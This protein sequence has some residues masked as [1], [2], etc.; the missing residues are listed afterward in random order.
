MCIGRMSMKLNKYDSMDIFL[1]SL[2]KNNGYDLTMVKHISYYSWLRTYEQFCEKHFLSAY[3]PVEKIKYCE[4]NAEDLINQAWKRI[5]GRA[6]QI[7][8]SEH[9]DALYDYFCDCG[10]IVRDECSNN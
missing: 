9:C 8:E 6:S 3:H 7:S 4:E 10:L 1:D 2:Q 5:C